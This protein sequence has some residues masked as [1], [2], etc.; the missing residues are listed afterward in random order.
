MAILSQG[1][2]GRGL[3]PLAFAP[4]SGTYAMSL[5]EA[6]A[7]GDGA[8]AQAIFRL[9]EAFALNDGVTDSAI[10]GSLRCAETLSTTDRLG[11]ALA[12][13]AGESLVMGDDLEGV[14]LKLLTVAEA[15][16]V[17]D[18]ASERMDWAETLAESFALLDAAEQAKALSV[19]EALVVADQVLDWARTLLS[20]SES[21]ALADALAGQLVMLLRAEEALGLG[22]TLSETMVMQLLCADTFAFIGRLPLADG[23]YSAW[24]VN[25]ETGGAW[26]YDNYGFNSFADVGGT[27]LGCMADGLYELTG[28]DDDGQAIAARLR[29]GLLDFGTSRLKNVPRAYLGYSATN[30]LVLKTFTTEGGAKRER[31]YRLAPTQAAAVREGRVRLARGVQARY[32]GFEVHSV[33][34]GAVEL[35]TLQLLPVVLKRRV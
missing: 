5:S 11:F 15:L 3:G 16:R 31:W 17:A 23:D 35:D 6:L 7:L 10:I 25:T 32:W 12:L 30:G 20:A 27:L 14:L 9:A 19:D 33:E 34:G 21:L 1:L 24:V 13:L 26:E 22:D 28:E 4:A 2:L 8:Q 18:G 29:T